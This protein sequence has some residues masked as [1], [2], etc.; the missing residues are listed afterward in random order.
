ME[1]RFPLALSIYAGLSRNCPKPCTRLF[2]TFL[3]H[4]HQKYLRGPHSDENGNCFGMCG[5]QGI[6]CVVSHA[7]TE[8]AQAIPLWR[9]LV[10]H[11]GD[12][13]LKGRSQE[14][15]ETCTVRLVAL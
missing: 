3:H 15:F 2:S 5:P 8:T 11:W 10:R 9:F 4:L 13:V 1:T 12:Q 7:R 14:Y 6:F